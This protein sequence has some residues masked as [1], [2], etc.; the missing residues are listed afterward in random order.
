M[1]G[2]FRALITGVAGFLGSFLAEHLLDSGD[3]VLGCSPDGLWQKSSPAELS[4]RMDLLAWDLGDP[5]GISPEARRRI[6]DFRP[7]CIYHLAALSVPG[8]C[9]GKEPTP[10][11]ATVNVG[12]TRQVM[13]LAASLDSRPRVL[14]ASTS[15]VYAPV[16]RHAPR[17]DETSPLGPRLAYAK[18]KLAAEEEVRRAIREHDCDAVIVRIFQQAGPRLDPRLMLSQWARQFVLGGSR[19]VE[20]YTLDAHIDLSDGRDSVRAYRLLI[21]H[22]R[23][24]EVY[25]LGSGVRRRS[26]DVLEILRSMT[27]PGRPI[28]E[29]DPGF[30]QDPIADISRLVRCTGWRATIPVETTVADTLAWWRSVSF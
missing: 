23:C 5:V 29:L 3:E 30:K 8:D 17:V 21:E 4:N 27:D 18:T 13:E 10:L 12:G 11:A 14:L 16:S 20:V 25:N 26:G 19:P 1:L 24:G 7:D 15:H 28:I 22:G 2:P 6:E 9:G